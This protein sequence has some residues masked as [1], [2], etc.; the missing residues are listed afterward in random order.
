MPLFRTSLGRYLILLVLSVEII[1]GI[2]AYFSQGPYRTYL[3]VGM[4]VIIVLFAAGAAAWSI[5]LRRRA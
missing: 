5:W 1:L 3:L 2:A 4:L